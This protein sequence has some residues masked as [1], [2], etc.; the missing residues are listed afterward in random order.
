MSQTLTRSQ[1]E[2]LIPHRN[3]ILLL[4]EVTGWEADTW[5]ESKHLFAE[6]NP[7]FEGHFPGNPMLPGVLM[8]EAMAQSAAVLT[9]LTRGLTSQTAYYV[10]TGIENVQFRTSLLPG[11]TLDMR[12]EKVRDK[13]NLYQ[14]TGTAHVEGKLAAKATFT[15][16]LILK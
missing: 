3:P 4:D 14:F 6:N 5:L 9:S 15:A 13:M 1:I 7:H 11:Q 12:V 16:K 10:F 8:V 2:D